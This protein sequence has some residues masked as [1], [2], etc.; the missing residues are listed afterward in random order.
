[1]NIIEIYSFVLIY[2][3]GWKRLR[4]QPLLFCSLPVSSLVS[5]P[6]IILLMMIINDEYYGD[7]LVCSSTRLDVGRLR[8]FRTSQTAIV[9]LLPFLPVCLVDLAFNFAHA[10]NTNLFYVSFLCRKSVGKWTLSVWIN[11]SCRGLTRCPAN[12]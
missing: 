4:R 11:T 6:I 5:T 12:I 9:V 10:H 1:M 8:T 3:F 2:S 7:L